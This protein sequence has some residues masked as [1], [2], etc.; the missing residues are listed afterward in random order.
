MGMLQGRFAPFRDSDLQVLSE[1]SRVRAWTITGL[2]TV[3]LSITL[4][5]R[6]VL[7]ALAV[8][9]TAS[10]GI[11]DVQYGWLSSGLASAF[12]LGSLPSARLIQR[13]GPQVGLAFTVLATSLVLGLHSIVASFAALMWL[14][15]G[16]GFAVTASMPSAAQ[17]IHH[18][19]PFKDR[20]RGIGLLYMGSSLGSAICPPLAVFLDAKF[21]WRGTF[22]WVAVIG[23]IWVPLWILV[24]LCG[25]S[26]AKS[27]ATHVTNQLDRK[28]HVSLFALARIPGVLRGSLLVAAAAPV[29]LVML[30]WAAKYLVL[31]HGIPQRQLGKYLWLP[32][33]LFGVGSIL[34]GEL[35]ARSARARASARPP[36]RLV[37]LAMFLCV[38]MAAVP[39]A[40]G[41][42][43]CVLVASVAMMGAGGL[44]TLATSDMLAQTPR[45]AVP[46]TAGFTTLTQSLVYIIA[47]PII[48]KSVEFFR[49]Y[50]WVMFGAG[51]WVLPCTL[52]WLADASIRCNGT[53]EQRNDN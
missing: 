40:H 39:F 35:R 37:A 36:R 41:P 25:K 31:D 12:L 5:H 14:R 33:L 23:M 24:S 30:I 13:I 2:A 19:L 21:G 42:Q 28:N 29:T 46:S 32:A 10:L 3:A 49:N 50:D 47:S 15:V 18:V 7:A 16:M 8:T 34:F 20:A 52:C 44:Y 22:Y 17:A 1:V 11:S 4:V 51:L 45:H 27:A 26:A 6:Q 43:A 48:G 9:V 38:L 53:N